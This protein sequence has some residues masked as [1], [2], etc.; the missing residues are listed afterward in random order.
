MLQVFPEL[1]L[2]LD[3]DWFTCQKLVI[4]NYK[5]VDKFFGFLSVFIC[6]ACVGSLPSYK[7]IVLPKVVM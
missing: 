3:D 5:N 7:L 4:F 1:V 2:L 6:P